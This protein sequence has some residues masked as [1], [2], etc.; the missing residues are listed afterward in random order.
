MP[1]IE[2]IVKIEIPNG[3]THYFGD[4]TDSPTFL[5][6]TYVGVVGAHWWWYDNE[7]DRWCLHNHSEE[8]PHWAKEIISPSSNP[9]P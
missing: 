1:T 7:K 3:A 2:V 8:P 9:Q 4:L 6:K 5:K